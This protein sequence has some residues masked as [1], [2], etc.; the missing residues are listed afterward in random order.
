M[1]DLATGFQ[2]LF[3]GKQFGLLLVFSPFLP[4]ELPLSLGEDD[5]SPENNQ[6]GDGA[7]IQV[8]GIRHPGLM[9]A[10]HPLLHVAI[11][12]QSHISGIGGIEELQTAGMETAFQFLAKWFVGQGLSDEQVLPGQ[13][14][15]GQEPGDLH[16]HVLFHLSLPLRCGLLHRSGA[17][18][19]NFAGSD[20][21]AFP[22]QFHEQR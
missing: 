4:F 9:L 20:D 18:G 8:H 14:L 17:H 6:Q 12:R 5:Q 11:E 2:R 22:G 1:R 21:N 10:E 13:L 16:A 3:V 15:V 7:S 19:R